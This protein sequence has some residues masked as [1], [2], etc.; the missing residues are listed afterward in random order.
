M[1]LIVDGMTQV[2]TKVYYAPELTS[3]L[4]SVGQLQ[5]KGV[6]FIFKE[7]AGKMYHP[8]KGLILASK[9]T[10][11]RL[12][13]IFA[14]QEEADRCMQ[15]TTGKELWHR[16]FA[17]ANHKALRTMQFNNMVEG[18]P[19][20]AE[21]TQLCEVC[22][23]GKQNRVEI[24]KKSKWH[25]SERLQLVHTDICGPIKPM[26]QGGK[27]YVLVFIDDYTRKTWVYLL[28]FKGEPFEC[29][30]RFKA[31]VEKETGFSLKCLRSDRGGEFTSQEFKDFC[32]KEG[33]KRQLIVAYT[34][35]QN[36]VAERRNRTIMNM[37]RCLLKEKDLPKFL[38]AEAVVWAC[39]VLNRTISRILDK[40]VPEELWTGVKPSVS[41]FRVFGCIG[42]VHGPK[43]LRTKL[44][45]W[46]TKVT[47]VYSLELV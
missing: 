27:R 6:T 35:Q 40:R 13:P 2:I 1:K 9:M 24:P 21:K 33:I 38:W 16:R 14:A 37:V 46:M 10:K 29:F 4:I 15:V 42:Y 34:P 18:L 19:K 25:A 17:H 47:S 43:Q 12:F 8:V 5:E 3:N 23:V 41:H 7:G 44:E 28:A 22:E 36:G 11:N 20:V 45:C 31:L 26:S 39:H 32:E 30:K